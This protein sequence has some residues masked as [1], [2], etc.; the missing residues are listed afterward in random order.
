MVQISANIDKVLLT[1]FREIIFFKHGLRKG[2]ITIALEE[3]LKDYIEKNA[4][5][6]S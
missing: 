6:K 1:R 3:A 2:D 4:Q 5:A